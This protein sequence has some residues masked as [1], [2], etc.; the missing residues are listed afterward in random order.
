MLFKSHLHPPSPSVLS[1]HP[2]FLSSN[3]CPP[4]RLSPT[5]QA[6]VFIFKHPFI[7][8]CLPVHSEKNSSAHLRPIATSSRM[9]PVSTGISSQPPPRS[10]HQLSYHHR[11]PRR[12]GSPT[13][14]CLSFL[15]RPSM[16]I[17]SPAS[18]H[19]RL[20]CTMIDVQ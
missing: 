20:A 17:Y 19:Q 2:Q 4:F 10:R 7:P 6:L 18:K 9:P 11:C 15:D 8:C 3:P 14:A 5:N 1:L 12:G 16:L 13:D